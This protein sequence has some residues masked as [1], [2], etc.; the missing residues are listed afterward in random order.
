MS[1]PRYGK[2]GELNSIEAVVNRFESDLRGRT[3]PAIESLQI[4]SRLT[5][6]IIEVTTIEEESH[7]ASSI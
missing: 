5:K 7:N 4:L 3:I 1:V 6:A 2:Y